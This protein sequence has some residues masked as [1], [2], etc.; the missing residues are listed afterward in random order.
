MALNEKPGLCRGQYSVRFA[1]AGLFAMFFLCTSLRSHSQSYFYFENKI[2]LPNDSSLTCYTLLTLQ[3]NGSAVA[4]IRYIEPASGE[5]RLIQ[6]NLLDSADARGDIHFQEQYLIQ[7]GKPMPIAET[8]MADTSNSG[9]NSLRFI[10]K[11][12]TDG[13]EDF[14]VPDAILYKNASGSW[15]KSEML[16]NLQVSDTELKEQ[17]EFLN[18]FYKKTEE[19]YKYIVER[20][21]Y[22]RS[23]VKRREKLYLIAVANT[24][25]VK[26]GITA[27][28]DIANVVNTFTQMAQ[29]LNMDILVQK[30]MDNAF[31][32]QS[33]EL[34]LAK[35]R[36]SPV[37]IV[38]FYFSGHGFRYS[39]DQ[40][41]Y[42]R[43]SLRIG[44]APDLAKNNLSLES[45][46][47][48]LLQKK[49]KVTL[50]LSDCCNDDIGSLVPSGSGRIV[51]K[52]PIGLK[53]ALNMS[54]CTQLFFPAKPTSII[55]G[56]AEKNQLAAGNPV[57][58]GYFTNV[59][60]A[61]LR[62]ALYS[63]AA[64]DSWRRVLA[65]TKKQA[66]WES[67]RAE[68][69]PQVRCVQSAK[70]EVIP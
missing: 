43:I 27:K 19:F 28:A 10:F 21:P 55:I 15:Q 23:P 40:S 39:E 34:A 69:A 5:P 9:F 65:S 12:Q 20:P 42:P 36:P 52:A 18:R 56:S 60:T 35:L 13:K 32:K 49:A 41:S 8:T 17:A 26:I 6:V 30:I 24:L 2:S 57:L 53:P 61:E 46:Y 54:V 22:F 3:S 59:F 68:C 62:K 29:D 38:V 31:G 63:V 44:T 4:R 64:S 58:G 14:Y 1:A 50:V 51:V 47:K 11:K 25:D 66:S 33:V 37:D 7:D 67:L 48:T 45:V 16:V 70:I